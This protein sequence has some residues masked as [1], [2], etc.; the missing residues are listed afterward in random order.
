M[1]KKRLSV[2]F[3]ALFI[4][5]G[6]GVKPSQAQSVKEA[7]SEHPF[8]LVK[9]SEYLELREHATQEP[10]KSITAKAIHQAGTL[11]Y[12]AGFRAGDYPANCNLMTEIMEAC[13]LAYILDQ[14]EN[15]KKLYRDKIL[16]TLAYW[17]PG[18]PGNL[19]DDL[20]SS[21]WNYAIP[22]GNAFFC[23]VL[24]L[25]IIYP[26]LSSAELGTAERRL[27]NVGEWFKQ[28]TMNWLTNKW[29]AYGV[30][31][32]YTNDSAGINE[33]IQGYTDSVL[34]FITP[35]GVGATGTGYAKARFS[36]TR[37]A[38]QYFMDILAHTKKVDFYQVPKAVNFYEWL[39]GYTITPFK[40]L[41]VFGDTAL[42]NAHYLQSSIYKAGHFS[43][44]AADYAAWLL[45]GRTQSGSLMAYA[46]HQK[47]AM[48]TPKRAPS[49]I[50][51]DGGAYFF[52]NSSSPM[53]LSSVLWNCTQTDGH[54][55]KEVNALNAAAYGEMLL[56]N[57]GY[58]GWATGAAG[59]SWDYI[60]NRAISGN[61]ALIDYTIGDERNPNT[62][63]D[64]QRK[65]GNGISEGFTTDLFGYACGDSGKALPNG[66][67]LRNLLSIFPQDG[68]NGYWVLFD[69]LQAA[70]PGKTA[71]IT[72]HAPT[73]SC[74][75]VSPL[76][77]YRWTVNN[78]GKNVDLSVFLGTAPTQAELKQGVVGQWGNSFVAPYLYATYQTDPAFGR[79]NIVTVLYPH[80]ST[81]TKAVMTQISGNGFTG[82]RIESAGGNSL[83]GTAGH[84]AGYTA[85]YALE[86][87]GSKVYTHEDVSWQGRATF[88]R[89]AGDTNKF[90][91]VRQGRSFY[92]GGS[93]GLGFSAASEVSVYM[94]GQSGQIV[95]PGTEVAFIYPGIS[96]VKLEGKTVAP[97]EKGNGW[98]MIHVPAGTSSVELITSAQGA[99]HRGKTSPAI[100]FPEKR[101]EL[102]IGSNVA[103]VDGQKQTIDVPPVL[104]NNRTMVPLRFIGEALGVAFAWDAEDRTVTYRCGG[105]EIQLVIGQPIA[106][107]DTPPTIIGGR[108]MVP[109]R[110]IAECFGAEVTWDQASQRVLVQMNYS[111]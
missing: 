28:S 106:G 52:E 37:Y 77:E 53:A 44:A 64:H 54:A 33:A 30:W 15:N 49:K 16:D 23:S 99:V 100:V 96:A 92:G 85:D 5:G 98:V 7:T 51:P 41:W 42:S 90:Y 22:P 19:R 59:F 9:E 1:M 71:H 60:F 56:V 101:L 57:A 10:W 93:S 61:T 50:F 78:L 97:K 73:T 89:M 86:S 31:A 47:S 17:E 80:D 70:I 55:H 20:S 2:L 8:L 94:L 3:L 95:S 40:Q 104:I 76:K 67:H 68:Q 24:A 72:L 66:K 65:N 27:G 39:Y 11:T 110:Y 46:L 36:E 38:K 83:G 84:T 21:N 25:D 105:Q 18:V 62:R 87:D 48:A 81:H 102:K 45:E 111:S 91:F 108:T 69:E 107:F 79:K 32:L 109:L 63:N 12:S 6:M 29:G 34:S 74:L 35:D 43:T 75:A 14:N 26:D 103:L 58:N 82:A 88:Y 13:S 4:L